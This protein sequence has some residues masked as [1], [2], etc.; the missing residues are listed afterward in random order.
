MKSWVRMLPGFFL[1][2]PQLYVL[3]QAPRGGSTLLISLEY[4]WMLSYEAEGRRVNKLNS[5][6]FGQKR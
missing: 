6:R 5:H 2:L 3:K 4:T 1:L